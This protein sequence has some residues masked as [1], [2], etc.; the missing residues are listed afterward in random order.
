MSRGPWPV[1]R[2]A[3]PCAPLSS[4]WWVWGP[5]RSCSELNPTWTH[6][7][8]QVPADL[9]TPQAQACPL[10]WPATCGLWAQAWPWGALQLGLSLCTLWALDS[11]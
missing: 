7:S 11:V 6:K 5:V 3:D 9:S 2:E 8:P 10:L 1:Q 4:V